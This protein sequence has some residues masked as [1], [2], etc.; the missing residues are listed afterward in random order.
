MISQ[1]LFSILNRGIVK[2][3]MIRY[4]IQDNRTGNYY[5]HLEKSWPSC[6][7]NPNIFEAT[8][9]KTKGGAKRSTVRFRCRPVGFDI[10]HYEIIPLEEVKWLQIV[11]VTVNIGP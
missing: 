10:H 6:R 5:Q 1:M 8:L 2:S 3:T 11:E 9:F 7:W 4:V